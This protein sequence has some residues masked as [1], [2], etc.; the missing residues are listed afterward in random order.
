MVGSIRLMAFA[1]D[2]VLVGA[3]IRTKRVCNEMNQTLA[4]VEEFLWDKQLA[5]VPSKTKAMGFSRRRV[6]VWPN[7]SIRGGPVEF[8]QSH[9]F[10]GVLFDDRM[11]WSEH[12]GALV[13]SC[14][15]G[16]N[17]LRTL[18]G[19]DWGCD[20]KT[21]LTVY[22][23]FVLSRLDYA[24]GLYSFCSR[25][26]L[27]QL[28]RIQN[29]CLRICLGVLRSTPINVLCVEDGVCP[30]SIRRSELTRRYMMRCRANLTSATGTRLA[31]AA[32]EFEENPLIEF[33]CPVHTVSHPIRG[34]WRLQSNTKVF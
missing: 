3:G 9:R 14:Y 11:S 24:F 5:V 27:A 15:Q 21:M 4:N 30:L 17:I 18:A 26:L 13:R 32:I 23:G 20:P 7:L 2:L 28:N 19:L 8:V 16:V 12:I 34:R 1:D 22:R 33:P 25:A 10:L 31:E 29:Q 6:R